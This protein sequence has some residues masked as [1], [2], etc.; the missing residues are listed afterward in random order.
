MNKKPL[1]ID[2]PSLQS[3]RQRYLSTFFT[4]LFW[5]VWIFLW[6]PLITLIGWLLGFDLIYSEMIELEGYKGV[7]AD[8]VLFISCVAIIGCLLGF[9]ALYNFLRF[10][11]VDRRAAL[12]PVNNRQLSAF[13]AVDPARLAIQQKTQ[14]LT[15]SFDADGN[16][17]AS[18]ELKSKP[19]GVRVQ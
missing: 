14:C 6:T 19:G 16:I 7:L 5:V 12:A 1:V 4:F 10:K 2:S 8:F 18:V 15:V 9:W 17:T 3:L 11:D 13:F